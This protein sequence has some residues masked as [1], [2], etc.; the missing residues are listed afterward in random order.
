MPRRK[1]GKEGIRKISKTGGGS[2]YVTIPIEVMR[3]LK[4]KERQKVVVKKQGKK[5]IIIDW[6]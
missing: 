3:E 6:K 2:F 4:W 1:A 5:I